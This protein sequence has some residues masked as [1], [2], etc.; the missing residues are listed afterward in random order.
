MFNNYSSGPIF[1][2][3]PIQC[4]KCGIIFHGK[5][6]EFYCSSCISHPDEDSNQLI[7]YIDELLKYLKSSGWSKVAINK[8][9]EY[10]IR[11]LKS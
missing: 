3:K 10:G 9:F 5:T 1:D 8:A 6:G 11:K 7:V 4:S 2:C